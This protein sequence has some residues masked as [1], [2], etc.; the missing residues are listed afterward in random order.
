[1]N[2]TVARTRMTPA[3]KA[4]VMVGVGIVTAIVRLTIAVALNA[5]VS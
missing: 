2:L 3:V 5:V 1:M 4:F